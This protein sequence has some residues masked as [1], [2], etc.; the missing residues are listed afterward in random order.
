[1]DEHKL[2]KKAAIRFVILMGIISLFADMT[3]EGARGIAGPFLATLGA[4]GLIVGVISG[5]GEFFGYALRLVSGYFSDR[6]R[7]YWSITGIGYA[8]NLLAVPLLS[9]ANAWQVAAF[10]L[11]VERMGKALRT[12]AR[13]AMLS[14]A[15]HATGRGRGFGLHEALDQIGAITGPLLIALVLFFQKNFA[16]AFAILLIPAIMA[17]SLLAY[18]RILYPHPE[19]LEIKTFSI[20]PTHFQMPYWLFLIGSCL[21]AAGFVDFPLIAYHFEKKAIIPAIWIP[22][23]FSITM[24]V[25][26]IA[27][28][29]L[30][31][32]YD[33]K[34]MIV[35]IISI[36]CSSFFPFFTF[37][38][39]F[40][41]AIV[42]IVLWGIGMGVQES[43]VRAMLAQ[44]VGTEKRGTGYG[45]FYFWYGI[46]WL[47]GSA[48]IGYMYDY[49][50]P[51]LILISFL[52]QMASLPF[53]YKAK[54][55]NTRARAHMR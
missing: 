5:L 31:K 8:I 34:G 41:W 10:L 32:L 16:L 23:L 42:G 24:G 7:A 3:Y 47:A 54:K 20:K 30:G 11:I 29:F 26:G 2:T 36:A 17:L 1:M 27:S 21:V 50:I 38:G 9:L 51:V 48:L 43:L 49:S 19:K 25:D 45:I 52:L 12:P 39:G 55:L 53:F 28:L 18:A 13:D 14:Y 35:L 6:T 46:A 37:L 33:K 15:T 4:S 22:I 44:L 40:N